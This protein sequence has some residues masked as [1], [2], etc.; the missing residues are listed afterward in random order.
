MDALTRAPHVLVAALMAGLALA[1]CFEGGPLGAGAPDGLD[2]VA[3]TAGPADVVDPMPD[4]VTVPDTS[5]EPDPGTPDAAPEL[6]EGPPC[7]SDFDCQAVEVANLC[8]GP[9]KCVDYVCRQDGS[10]PVTCEAPDDACLEA[11][12]DPETGGCV[13]EPVCVCKPLAATLK[14]GQLVKLSTA[15]AG[16]TASMTG[17]ACGPE[18]KQTGEH[19]W[20]FEA[21]ADGPVKVTAKASKL[22][23]IYVLGWDGENC[24]RDECVGGGEGAV[25]FAAQ[26]GKTYAVVVE[27]PVGA[28]VALQVQLQCNIGYELDCTDGVDDDG[29]GLTDCDDV[30]DCGGLSG[31]APPFESV[32]DDEIDDDGDGL[33]DCAD[34][35]C[36][37]SPDC[38]QTCKV[39]STPMFTCSLKTYAWA[40]KSDSL[41]TATDYACPSGPTVAAGREEGFTFK[42]GMAAPGTLVNV[43][44][45]GAGPLSLYV[46]K[47]QAGGT[48]ECNPKHCAAGGTKSANFVYNPGETY[49]FV[50]EA[51]SGLALP[52]DYTLNWSCLEP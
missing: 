41:A 9:V 20:L 50:V 27:H 4:V 36:D 13:E 26:A 49:Y 28:P 22:S 10:A 24:Q 40:V 30:D 3:D 6:P 5:K 31:C 51:A 2:E 46:L 32:C 18:S 38:K 47:N 21:K 7:L 25:A 14:C 1:A 15:D 23:G 8:L 37:A 34:D 12:C 17:Y 29:D 33:T 43:Q 42:D 45:T 52:A 19:T 48:G 44:L 16:A 11:V 39:W 35:D